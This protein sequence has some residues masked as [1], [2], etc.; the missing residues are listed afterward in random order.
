[1]KIVLFI[2]SVVASC[3]GALLK[4]FTDLEALSITLIIW[5]IVALIGCVFIH[6]STDEW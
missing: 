2:F 5:G 6:I 4:D 3:G 1:M